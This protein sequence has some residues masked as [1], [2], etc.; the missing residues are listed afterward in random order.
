ME[1]LFGIVGHSQ[2]DALHRMAALYGEQGQATLWTTATLAAGLMGKGMLG[3]TDRYVVSLAGHAWFAAPQP[4]AQCVSAAQIGAELETDGLAILNRLEGHF[5]LVV[6]D[7]V[8][9]ALHL[10]R[11]PFGVSRLYL[12]KGAGWI[13]YASDYKALL[14]IADADAT[15]NRSE[16]ERFISSGWIDA[17]QTLFAAIRQ[18]LPGTVV[19]L[20]NK[21]TS[22]SWLN[23]RSRIDKSPKIPVGPDDVLERLMCSVQ[24]LSNDC[25]ESIGVFLSGGVDSAVV[26]AALQKVRP[27]LRLFTFTV[28]YGND[29]P[30]ILNA[31]ESARFL[32]GCHTETIVSP[33]HLPT[34]I[35]RAFWSLEDP[36]GND[37]YVCLYAL[38]E[39]AA[40][41]VDVVLS[42]NASD[43]LFAGMDAHRALWMGQYN[44]RAPGLRTDDHS[45]SS[46]ARST[47]LHQHLVE[48]LDNYDGRMGAQAAITSSL[49]LSL[50]MPFATNSMIEI[51]LA[52]TDEQKI[53][54][55]NNKIVLR[56]AAAKLLPEYI[57]WRKKGLLHLKYDKILLELLSYVHGRIATHANIKA[58]NIVD[59]DI[60]DS[61]MRACQ[62]SYSPHT[63]QSL[64]NLVAI[65]VWF[66]QFLERRSEFLSESRCRSLGPIDF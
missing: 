4:S 19:T 21:E 26:A 12:T 34:L 59:T 51:G 17:G 13:A 54:S 11:D 1:A 23:S 2:Q 38:T 29:D 22:S 41:T 6:W 37:E 15:P 49:G 10:A 58:F 8:T 35:P 20:R 31:R 36:C 53:D 18:V 45:G 5:A 57:A 66:L 3:V 61:I 39:Q 52:S 63:L 42:G 50:R 47:V 43:T 25:E 65:E 7:Q 9:S 33:E 16:V 40:N 64:W 32:D 55:S 14:T 46:A 48:T 28:G 56:S 44:G 30:E 24:A 60:F 62:H 27:N